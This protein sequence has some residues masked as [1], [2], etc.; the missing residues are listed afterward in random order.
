MALMT[1]VL[2]SVWEPDAVKQARLPGAL[3]GACSV[4]NDRAWNC[5]IVL[6]LF[7]KYSVIY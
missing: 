3:E 1:H 4:P 6:F 2:E 5:N 7:Y